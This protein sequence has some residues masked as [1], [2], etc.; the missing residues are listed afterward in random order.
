MTPSE[1]AIAAA[2]A[3]GNPEAVIHD[4]MAALFPHPGDR[5]AHLQPGALMEGQYKFFVC[6]GFLATPDAHHKM[7]VGNTGLPSGSPRD[8]VCLRNTACSASVG[9]DG[10]SWASKN[11]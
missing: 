2:R 9:E 1:A 4:A 3:A 10:E 7:L 5:T 8:S 6:G 11:A